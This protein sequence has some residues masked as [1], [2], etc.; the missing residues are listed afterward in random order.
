MTNVRPQQLNYDK[1]ASSKYDRD[2]VNSI[3]FHKELHKEIMK[4]VEKKF[5]KYQEYQVLDLGVGTGLTSKLMQDRLPNAQLEVVDFSR[6]MLAGAKK[7]LGTKNVHYRCVDYAKHLFPKSHYDLVLS[8]IGLHHQNKK[9]NHT[10]TKKMFKKIFNMLKPGGVFILGDLVTYK[11]N[12][13]AALNN[14][15]HFAHLVKKSTDEKTLK[16]WVHHHMYLNH[17]APIEDQITWLKALGFV[18]TK[19]FLKLNTGLLI[20]KKPK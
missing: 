19:A 5:S 12:G 10:G 15:K 20:C 8:V 18:V 2:I 11:D 13:V 14:A 4:F 7:R 1:Y 16:E 9:D 17:L 6:N 3:P